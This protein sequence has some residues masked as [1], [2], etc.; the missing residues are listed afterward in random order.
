ME[1]FCGMFVLEVARPGDS[2]L[3]K[4]A[5]GPNGRL[6]PDEGHGSML[7]TGICSE[8][9]RANEWRTAGRRTPAGSG[10]DGLTETRRPK[11]R[12][13]RP[14]PTGVPNERLCS[15]GWNRGPQR[16]PL[17]VGA[18][19][20]GVRPEQALRAFGPTSNFNF[21]SNNRK[22]TTTTLANR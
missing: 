6:S 13:N 19:R 12:H 11:A 9:S 16:A 20:R 14:T 1:K 4:Q 15:L 7:F 8:D 5:G 2:K 17:A 10:R 3:E 22:S 18:E 21:K